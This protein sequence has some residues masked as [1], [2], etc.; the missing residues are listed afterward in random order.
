MFDLEGTFERMLEEKTDAWLV[1]H[2]PQ[3]VDQMYITRDHIAKM[4]DVSMSLLLKDR[5]F[6]RP[7]VLDLEEPFSSNLRLFRYPEIKVEIE[8]YRYEKG[9]SVS[10]KR[11]AKNSRKEKVA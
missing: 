9:L 10:N 3:E 7:A 8:K 11:A 6:S 2:L 5:F 4:L 1:K